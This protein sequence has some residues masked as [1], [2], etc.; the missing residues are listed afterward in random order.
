MPLASG[1]RGH[2]ACGTQGRTSMILSY[3][4]AGRRGATVYGRKVLLTSQ[5]HHSPRLKAASDRHLS[6]P[7]PSRSGPSLATR[8]RLLQHGG[9]TGKT[10]ARES[11]G[12]AV[13]GFFP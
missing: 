6:P 11:D 3:R 2:S 13:G 5:K 7:P 12:T 8:S 4:F 10:G 9:R 1:T